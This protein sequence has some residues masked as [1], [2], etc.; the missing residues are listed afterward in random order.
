VNAHISVDGLRLYFGE[1][2]QYS[3]ATF[4]RRTTVAIDLDFHKNVNCHVFK[5]V[6][7]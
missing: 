7:C 2:V 3:L 1:N 4:A 5:E 6:Y